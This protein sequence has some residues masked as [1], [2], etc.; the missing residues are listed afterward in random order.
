MMVSKLK[1]VPFHKVNSPLAEPVS[2]LRPS[3]VHRTKF[4]GCLF[5]FR[6]SWRCFEGIESAGFES[7]DSG[8]SI[9]AALEWMWLVE[10]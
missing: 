2:N 4:T 8:G 10:Y 9:Y 7:L 3:G 6:E 5:L 1:P